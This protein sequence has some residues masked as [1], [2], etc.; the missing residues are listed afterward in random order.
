MNPHP[1]GATTNLH[2]LYQPHEYLK[3]TYLIVKKELS[4]VAM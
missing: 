4:H 1:V 2:Q 3:L